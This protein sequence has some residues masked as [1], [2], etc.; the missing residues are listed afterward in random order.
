[1]AR[2]NQVLCLRIIQMFLEGVFDAVAERASAV[3]EAAVDSD[4]T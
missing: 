2:E 1:M 4:V 3:H